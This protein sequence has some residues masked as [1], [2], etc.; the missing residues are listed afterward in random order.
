M[1]PVD[2][3]EPPEEVF[4]SP[5]DIVPAGLIWEIVSKRGT[6]KLLLEQIHF[7]KEEN[8]T[9]PHEPAGVDDGVKKD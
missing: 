6:S 3:I 4:C 9:G 2:L 8:D 7:V 5:V 1:S